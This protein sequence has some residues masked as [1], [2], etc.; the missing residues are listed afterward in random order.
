MVLVFIG[1]MATYSITLATIVLSFSV[2]KSLVIWSFRRELKLL[3]V[4]SSAADSAEYSALVDS[5]QAIE[6]IKASRTERYV[7]ERWFNRKVECE[8]LINKRHVVKS[9]QSV[10]ISFIDTLTLTTLLFIGCSEVATGKLSLGGYFIFLT[11]KSMFAAPFHGLLGAYESIQMSKA[12]MD[13]LDDVFEFQP[14]P[15]GQRP[16]HSLLGGVELRDVSFSYA[17]SKDPAVSGV[18]ISVN[19][20]SMVAIV[21]ASGSGKTTLAKI[22]VGLYT[23]QVGDVLYDGIPMSTIVLS[24]LRSRI[25]VVLQETFLFN[26]TVRNNIAMNAPDMPIHRV[27]YAAQ[28]ACAD[29]FINRLPNGYDTIL[30]DSGGTLSGG[31]RQRICLARALAHEPDIILLDEATSALD[32]ATEAS[33]YSNLKSMGCTRIVIAHRLAT[34]IDSDLI[35]VMEQGR[36]VQMGPYELISRVKGPFLQILE[37]MNSMDGTTSDS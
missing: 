16:C 1:L 25:G 27:I 24:E 13:R 7:V 17:G 12:Y 28:Q 34:V 8:N 32:L 6:T 20:G 33:I 30:G 18:N 15:S 23:P 3:S 35:F 14:E 26:D 9:Y 22:L 10:I 31:Q 4:T 2:L 21:G 19:P 5:L 11:M 29:D 37:S 36:V